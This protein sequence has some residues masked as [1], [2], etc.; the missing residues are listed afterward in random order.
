MASWTRGGVGFREQLS[1]QSPRL[2][3]WKRCDAPQVMIHLLLK[4]HQ[5]VFVLRRQPDL[6]FLVD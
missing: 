1:I 6:D 5:F 2:I 3:K 4:A